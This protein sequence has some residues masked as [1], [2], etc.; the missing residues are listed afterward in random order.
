MKEKLGMKFYQHSRS[1]FCTNILSPKN[2]KAKLWLEKSF[3]N[4]FVHKKLLINIR[5]SETNILRAAFF[6]EKCC[7]KFLC[8]YKLRLLKEFGAN[9]ECKMLVKL[10]TGMKF[11][12]NIAYVINPS[13]LFS[14]YNYTFFIW[15]L[16]FV[17]KLYKSMIV[18]VNEEY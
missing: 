5:D 6:V 16:F 13:L 9:A 3:K 7:A 8:D 11:H 17:I 12:N 2:Y 1:S 10:T 14:K 15:I 4:A 18:S